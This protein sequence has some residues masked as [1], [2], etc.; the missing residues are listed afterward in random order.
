MA[1]TLLISLGCV[2]LALGFLL[3]AISP[4]LT[5]ALYPHMAK[6]TSNLLLQQLPV[7]LEWERC[8][9]F[10]FSF[11]TAQPTYSKTIGHGLGRSNR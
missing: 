9:L 6:G 1:W 4:F 11:T 7:R 8:F 10:F 3:M 2:A 5:S